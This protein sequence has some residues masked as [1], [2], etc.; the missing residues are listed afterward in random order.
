MTNLLDRRGFLAGSSALIAALSLP[1]AG[2]SQT[3]PLGLRATTRSLDIDGRAAT[4]FGLV[5]GAGGQGL[6][7]DPG[8]RF[9]V[10]LTNDL[11]VPTIVHWHGQIPPNVQD[12][13][14]DMPLPLLRPGETRSYDFEPAAGTHW[15]HSHVP[16]QEM[17]LLAAPLIVRRPD[18]VKADRQEVTIFLHDFSFRP[19]EEVLDEIR[20]GKGHPEPE[21]A[22]DAQGANAHAGHDMGAMGT[23]GMSAMEGMEGM[24]AAGMG[25]MAMDLNDFNFD[26]YLA[27][28]RTLSDPEIVAVEKGGRVLLRVINGAAATVFWIA[29][30]DV[31]ARLVAVDGQPVQA[32]PAA[33]FG[34][35]MGQRLD[36]E[37]DLP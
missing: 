2:L 37:L 16:V 12:G 24:T 11:D 3:A 26:A 1:R 19:P 17:Q 8:Q 21:T 30:G 27:N 28:D 7:L 18:D 31:P 33:R 35:A 5:N 4:V 9:L 32:L 10:N 22:D 14:P 15:M 6:V 36:I 13:V 25:G 29:C 20:S 23:S 34:V